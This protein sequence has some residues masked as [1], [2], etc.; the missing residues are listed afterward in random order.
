MVKVLVAWPTIDEAIANKTAGKW[1]ER[2]Y[3]TAVLVEGNYTLQRNINHYIAGHEW[4]GFPHAANELCCQFHLLYDIIVVGGDD[5][6]PDTNF[7]AQ[8]IGN[9]FLSYFNGTLGLMHPTGDRYGCVD[10]ASVC[11]WIGANYIK[12]GG[13]YFEGYY[14]YYCDAELQDVAT[15]RGLFW[16]R[17]DLSQYHDHWGRTGQQRPKHL[18]TANSCHAADKATY[19]ARKAQSFPGETNVTTS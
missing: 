14:H 17:P 2:G 19:E 16:Q 8:E 5:L 6:F 1:K 10:I 9:Q 18:M 3:D 4:K 7:T 11:P 15:Q 13:P 12:L